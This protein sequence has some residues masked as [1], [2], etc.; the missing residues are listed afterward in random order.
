MTEKVLPE[1]IELLDEYAASLAWHHC[2][3]SRLCDGGSGVPD[4]IIAGPRG[5]LW[6]EVKPGS[7][8]G[9]RPRQTTWKHMLLASGQRHVVWTQADLD[10]GI[11]REDLDSIT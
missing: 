9:L 7:W 4:L 8:S 10:N 6:A 5:V 11:V 3:D 1:I 2:R